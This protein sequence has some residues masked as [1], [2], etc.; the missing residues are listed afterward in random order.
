M[1]VTGITGVGGG[2][3]GVS[4]DAVTVVVVE[5]DIGMDVG[6]TLWVA[7]CGLGQVDVPAKD[8]T[9]GAIWI[10]SISLIRVL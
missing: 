10:N 2:R 9:I 6:C 3:G 1:T 7:I 4:P 8:T 5:P